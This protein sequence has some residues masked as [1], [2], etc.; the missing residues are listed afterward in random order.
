M[1]RAALSEIVLCEIGQNVTEWKRGLKDFGIE[2]G[3]ASFPNL[4]A[5]YMFS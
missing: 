5:Q 2:K 4:T 1:V 3:Y